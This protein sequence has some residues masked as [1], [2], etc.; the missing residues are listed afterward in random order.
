[1]R[2]SWNEIRE[3]A[4]KFSKDWENATSEQAERQT[5]WN[6]FFD[7]FDVKRKI[8]ASFEEPV[9]KLSGQWGFIDLFWK[10]VLL[11]E[12]K[13]AGKSLDKA[14]SQA[15]D[16][17]QALI[18]NG[19]HEEVPRY[20]II[21]DFQRI[22]L[23]DYEEG[24]S[25]V[26]PLADFHKHIHEFGFIPGYRQAKIGAVEDPINVRAV[27]VM[28]EFHDALEAGGY[29]GHDLERFLVRILF[30]L[31]A[32]DTGIFERNAFVALIE[33]HTKEDGSDLGP[34]LAR[35]FQVLNTP[36]ENR[37]KNLLEDLAEFPYVNGRLFE[38]NL[39]F[40]DLN[41]AMRKQLIRCCNLDWSRISPAVFGSLF[42]SVMEPK[43]RR[44]VGAHYTSERDILKLIN[45]LFMDELREEFERVKS[46]P[47]SLKAFHDRL[48]SLK[49]LD[50]ACGCGNFLV[51][52][53]RELRLLELEVLKARH[54]KNRF[55][56]VSA[57]CLVDVDAMFGI[58]I[59][60]FPALIAEVAMWLIDHQMNLALS[61]T[62]GQYF[63]RLPLKKS[64]KIAHG[65]ALRIN[66]ADV[67]KPEICSYILGNP[68]FVGHHYQSSSQRK[69]QEMVM[70]EI[71]SSGV[72]DY[73]ANW[74][75]KA[76]Q[77]NQG[78]AIEIGFVSTN[79]ICQGEQASLIWPVLLGKYGMKI[80][81]A[82]RTFSWQSEAKGKAHVHCV[83]VGLTRIPKSAKRIYEYVNNSELASVTV[84]KNISPYLVG[85][86]DAVV[87]VRSSPLCNVPKMMWGN[88][89]TDGGHLIISPTERIDIL[90]REPELEPFIRRFLGGGDLLNDIERYCF[91]LKDASPSTIKGS[92]E[93]RRRTEAVR[94]FRQSSKAESTRK[95]ASF[96]F[97]FRQISQPD[98]DYLA[99]PEVSSENRTYIPIVFLKQSVICS[100][101][102]QF[103]ADAQLWHFGILESSMHMAWMRVVCGRLK[104]DYRYS[105]S[106]VYNNFPWPSDIETKQRDGINEKAQAVLDIRERYSDCSLAELY[107]P[108]SMP[109]DLL[110]AHQ[111][112]D[113]AVEKCYRA[114]A[115]NSDR[116]R[117][118]FL[119]EL[120]E[121]LARPLQA[122]ER[123]SK[124][125]R[126]KKPE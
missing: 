92:P 94:E 61:E 78:H 10:G 1:M 25:I 8:V 44:Q 26:F 53:Y 42:Q 60:E 62:F 20:V 102:L 72:I 19:R 126:K 12:H 24:T 73:V 88:K 87:T 16:Y 112:L 79:S 77:F 11:V 74:Y 9:K 58:E 49:F 105:N 111:Q 114:K 36:V 37:Q 15:N 54:A 7:V 75:V 81:F 50:P 48:G 85:G 104:S 123:E 45:S 80:S 76:A 2:R 32:E 118:E 40:A 84:V 69:D 103:V 107:D 41:A 51:V 29:G 39:G 95:F 100:N 28:G 101:T 38:E 17:I 109:A 93:L 90:S 117:V 108:L 113:R 35:L 106:I 18:T 31:F 67:I 68:P 66:W 121:S 59:N 64:A 89:P 119:F 86:S 14:T 110:K 97:L 52:T 23:H 5:F 27:E 116:E 57:F 47:R 30:C 99:V 122:A 22:A 124:K 34:L 56:D 33:N 71:Q 55:T 115:F 46:N 125:T 91:W 43:E 65:N 83:I 120:Y 4:I 70:A 6:E 63:V 96:P 82:H 21:S 98:T 3:H 13:S